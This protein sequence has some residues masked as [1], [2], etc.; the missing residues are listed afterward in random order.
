MGS[1]EIE[2]R[3]AAG[4]GRLINYREKEER[5][6]EREKREEDWRRGRAEEWVDEGRSR[7]ERPAQRRNS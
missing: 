7:N 4:A 5:E 6:R 1:E 2:K 3:A